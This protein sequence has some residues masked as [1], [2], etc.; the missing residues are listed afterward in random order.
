MLSVF[1]LFEGDLL[2]T[3]E[4]ISAAERGEDVDA[5]G[6][7]GAVGRYRAWPGGVIPY[8]IHDS[9]SMEI[10]LSTFSCRNSTKITIVD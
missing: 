7:H 3:Q 5:A 6:H 2:L 10:D 9:A 4:E 1:H 8:T